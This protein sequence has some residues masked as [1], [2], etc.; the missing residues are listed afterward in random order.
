[1]LKNV[2]FDCGGV[3]YAYNPDDI[4]RTF[5]PDE[6]VR[7]SVQPILYRNW[8]ALDEGSVDYDAYARETV[9]M[10]PESQ[11]DAAARFFRK[12]MYVLP[13]KPEIWSLAA[14]LK[15]RG[16]N[17][18][19]LSNAPTCFAACLDDFP[20]LRIMDG[21]VVSAAIQKFKPNKDI[22]EYTLNRFHLNPSE[23]M[24]IDDNSPNTEAAKQLG[25]HAFTYRGEIDALRATVESLM[26]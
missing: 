26:Q 14:E 21:L 24:F 16:K 17:V 10:L 3:L 13:P 2:I 22:Y 20:I 11:R 4:T 12:W 15:A 7:Q 19:L 18:Y 8:Q 5:F 23:T 25:I 9:E 6:A 1:M